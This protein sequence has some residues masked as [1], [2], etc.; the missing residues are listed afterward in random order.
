VTTPP[1]VT[2]SNAHSPYIPNSVIQQR[3]AFMSG[4]ANCELPWHADQM[5][6]SADP[7]G[8]AGLSGT[9]AGPQAARLLCVSG[10]PASGKTQLA[11]ALAGA[12]RLPL[13]SRDDLKELAFDTL[14]WSDRT[15]SRR[16]GALSYQLLFHA[17]GLLLATGARFL[18][19]ANLYPQSVQRLNRLL[20][21]HHAAAAQ[22]HLTAPPEV[23]VG[24][25]RQRPATGGRHP[26]H[27]DDQCVEEVAAQC[28]QAQDLGALPRL[29]GR[30]LV[31]DT[32]D[33][34][35][36]DVGAV[37]CFLGLEAPVGAEDDPPR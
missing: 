8:S 30:L 21:R 27:V 2:T 26:G 32:T 6:I 5:T 11:R 33:F 37:A 31:L 35:N 14:G 25:Y 29:H 19:E 22:V 1:P 9:D 18:L 3:K 13:L 7:Q 34:R 28:A 16:L 10:P 20:E 24:R 36:V 4:C 23:L 12:Y 15:W 17:T